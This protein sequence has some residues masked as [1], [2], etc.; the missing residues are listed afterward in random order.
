[1]VEEQRIDAARRTSH[2]RRVD[3]NLSRV[4]YDFRAV[5]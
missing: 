4:R 2:A 1:V 5:T 3:R